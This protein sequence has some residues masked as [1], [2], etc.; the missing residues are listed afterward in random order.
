ML[1]VTV[2]KWEIVQRIN[3]DVNRKITY[4]TDADKYPDLDVPEFW[5][6]IREE[7]GRG[8][9]DDYALTKRYLLRGEFP[10][11]RQCFRLAT[12]WVETGEYHAVLLVD[13]NRG[14]YVLDNRER[15]IISWE[16]LDYTW[17]KI[18]RPDGSWFKYQR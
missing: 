9:C 12:C 2:E 4:M 6:V 11:H 17:D 7:R 14:T 13:T 15:N 18:Q 8:D 3:K 10:D 1:D 16:S 5:E